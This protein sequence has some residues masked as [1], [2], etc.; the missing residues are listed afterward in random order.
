MCTFS[1]TSGVTLTVKD[2]KKALYPARAKWRSIGVELD[3]ELSDLD[4]IEDRYASKPDGNGRCLEEMIRKS[5]RNLATVLTAL[6]EVTV[7]EEALAHD[8]E[9]KYR[10]LREAGK[11]VYATHTSCHT[12][13]TNTVGSC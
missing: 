5:N 12:L 2:L 10:S 7:D 8:I 3:V 6:R 13:A 4:D 1:P 9:K 11:C